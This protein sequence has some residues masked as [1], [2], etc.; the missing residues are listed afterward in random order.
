MEN[1]E[2][3]R[4]LFDSDAY[5]HLLGDGLMGTLAAEEAICLA[6]LQENDSLLAERAKQLAA[7]LIRDGRNLHIVVSVNRRQRHYVGGD[8]V[9]GRRPLYFGCF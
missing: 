2:S 4:F 7:D 5:P 3:S 1:P 8:T 6:L 9:L